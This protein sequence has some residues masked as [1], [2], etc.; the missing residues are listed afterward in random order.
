[1]QD[2]TGGAA[3]VAPF[4]ERAR[5]PGAV[6]AYASAET[7]VLG[8]V[9]RWATGRWLA[10]Y[11]AEKIWQPMGAEA[12]ATWLVDAG[13]YETAY[14]GINATL[15][16][17]ARLGMLLANDGALGGRQIVPA[18][19]VRAMTTPPAPQF[20]P[21]LTG[22][23]LGYGYQTWIVD[24]RRRQFMLRGFRG[25]AIYVDPKAKLVMVHTRAGTTNDGGTGE[26]L[27]LWNGVV[28]TL[29]GERRR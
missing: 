8:L 16:D 26:T 1:L 13:G 25:Q 24:E 21:G 23:L 2:G 15:R 4:N 19:W 27:A 22:V 14:F 17:Y 9:V 12:D 5:W 6:F 20:R 18:A 28:D 29:S 7:Q 3:A 11:L 10:D